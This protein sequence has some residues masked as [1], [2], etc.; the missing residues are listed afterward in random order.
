ML[1]EGGVKFTP[2]TTSGFPSPEDPTQSLLG[3]ELAP[4]RAKKWF[5]NGAQPGSEIIMDSHKR[6]AQGTLSPHLILCQERNAC[7]T[8]FW[9]RCSL[10]SVKSLGGNSLCS[11]P[12]RGASFPFNNPWPSQGGYHARRYEEPQESD[13]SKC[14]ERAKHWQQGHTSKTSKQKR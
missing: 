2:C 8:L 9:D 11:S 12:G 10:E 3:C 6:A 14:H 13:L 1:G 7:K 5:P 4:L